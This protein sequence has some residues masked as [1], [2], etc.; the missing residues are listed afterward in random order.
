MFQGEASS[1]RF[2]LLRARKGIKL[3]SLSLRNQQ[4]SDNENVHHRQTEKGYRYHTQRNLTG[5]S[6]SMHVLE[7]QINYILMPA[8]P[9]VSE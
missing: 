9:R 7:V 2:G 8:G 5:T 1:P 3:I 4:V 6:G